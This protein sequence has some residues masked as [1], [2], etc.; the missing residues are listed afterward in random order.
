MPTG[1]AAYSRIIGI[2]PRLRPRPSTLPKAAKITPAHVHWFRHRRSGLVEPFATAEETARRLIGVQAQLPPAADVAFFNRTADCTV[3]DLAKARLE[4]KTLVR[5]WGQRNTVHIYRTA[6]WPFLHSAFAER[7][8][9]MHRRLERAGLLGDFRRFVRRI[10]KR[11][12]DGEVLTYK[13]IKSKKLEGAQD[14]WVVSYLVLMELVR[15]GV[16]CHGADRG[17][18]SA[19]VRREHW[20][21]DLAWSPPPEEDAY[22]ELARRYLSTYGP[23]EV[24]DL[25]FW[26]GTS[27]TNARRWIESAGEDCCAVE[28]A[29]RTLWCCRTD[30]QELAVKPPARSRFPVRL[31]YRFDPLLLA[32]KDKS[33]LIDEEH[34]KLVWKGSAHVDPVLLVGGCI[35]GTWRYDREAKGLRVKVRPFATLSRTVTREVEKEAAGIADFFGMPLQDFEATD[36]LQASR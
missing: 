7:Q 34:Y 9:I 36:S 33:W 30:L 13:D 32:T 3:A 19:F 12:G 1:C 31:L 20:L 25:A 5:F 14:K 21:P 23:A 29:D 35:A 8:S 11:L 10:G 4:N 15:E 17:S 16:A 18:E 28:V 2:S 22:P 24:R 26:Y 6:D 27:A